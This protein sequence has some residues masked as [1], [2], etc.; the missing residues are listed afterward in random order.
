M[1][2]RRLNCSKKTF[3]NRIFFFIVMAR[4]KQTARKST[5]GK[6]PRVYQAKTYGPQHVDKF[7]RKEWLAWLGGPPPRRFYKNEP[8]RQL[9]SFT[10]FMDFRKKLGIIGPSPMDTAQKG[11]LPLDRA[12]PSLPIWKRE[13]KMFERY[14]KLRAKEEKRNPKLKKANKLYSLPYGKA[15]TIKR[16]WGQQIMVYF[17]TNKLK[18]VCFHPPQLL[19]Y[20][21]KPLTQTR[22]FFRVNW[23]E[24]SK[25]ALKYPRRKPTPSPIELLTSFKSSC[26]EKLDPSDREKVDPFLQS[27]ETHD[28][29]LQKVLLQSLACSFAIERS[30][31]NWKGCEAVSDVISSLLPSNNMHFVPK[32]VVSVPAARKEGPTGVPKKH[33][34][35]YHEIKPAISKLISNFSHSPAPQKTLL[36]SAPSNSI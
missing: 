13:K 24:R 20:V 34:L 32:W 25:M 4:T 19:R 16:R 1:T 29:P 11:A 28:D 8:N 12:F 30:E 5:G 2:N 21:R 31:Q 9:K 14:R 33:R 27:L 26:Y 18:Y 23:R 3:S 15:L 7:P 36:Y 6:S 22:R 10:V 35:R 17:Q